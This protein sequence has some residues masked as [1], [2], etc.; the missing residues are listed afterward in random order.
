MAPH[1]P[2]NNFQTFQHCFNISWWWG[3]C[4]PLQ[5]VKSVSHVWLFATPMDCSPPG[6][7]V[8]GIF[9]AI[10]LEWVASS[11]SNL[12]RHIS[13]HYSPFSAD[14]DEELQPVCAVCLRVTMLSLLCWTSPHA[15]AFPREHVLPHPSPCSHSPLPRLGVRPLLC[16]ATAPACP[17][18]ALVTSDHICLQLVLRKFQVDHKVQG[19]GE[20]HFCLLHLFNTQ[21]LLT[22]SDI[23]KMSKTVE[24]KYKWLL[25]IEFFLCS[26]YH[27]KHLTQLS[28][29]CPSKGTDPS[30]R[31]GPG[32]Q[33]KKLLCSVLIL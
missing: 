2:Q 15:L 5:E 8:H 10:I 26:R 27:A 30:K 24:N 18:T 11:S 7:S 20:A 12:F 13:Y 19:Q 16:P 23:E 4:Q 1:C 33:N 22:V 29:N 6:P 32:F 25:F 14:H 31:L 9:Q 21:N 17:A 3:P 28:F